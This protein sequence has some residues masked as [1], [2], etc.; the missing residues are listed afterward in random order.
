MEKK[1]LQ[2]DFAPEAYAEIEAL[3]EKTGLTTKAEVI[4]HA[5]RCLQWIVEVQDEGSAIL[6]IDRDDRQKEVVFPFLE[7]RRKIDTL[8]G[9][10]A[11]KR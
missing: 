10:L 11:A 1:R 8:R 2:F 6:V 9:E 4:R 7:K 3:Q 5:L